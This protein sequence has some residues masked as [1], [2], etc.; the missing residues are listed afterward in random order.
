MAMASGTRVGP[1]EVVSPLGAG[2]MGQVYRARDIKLNRDVALK[3][4]P[5]AFALDTDRLARFKREAQVLAWLDHPNISAIYGFEDS[6]GM[7]AL[8]LQ[9]V[10]GPTLAD[11]IAQG[12]M[13]LDEAVAVARQIA[14]TLEAAHKKGVIHRGLKPANIKLTTDRRVKV[15]DFG[16]A[17]LVA[18]PG[19]DADHT[20]APTL[21]AVRAQVGVILGTAGY[22]SPEQA[23]GTSF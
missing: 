15:L 13:P 21:T 1:Y 6:D 9:L 4:P 10:E 18:S 11:R 14:E 23:R 16:L 17:K 12:P 19:D 7:H 5:D 2:G 3:I 20:N 22:M 8:V